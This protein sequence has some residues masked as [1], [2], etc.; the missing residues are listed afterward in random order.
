MVHMKPSDNQRAFEQ[1][2]NTIK[3]ILDLINV[4]VEIEGGEPDT[5]KK[6]FTVTNK[7]GDKI[8]FCFQ[9]TDKGGVVTITNGSLKLEYTESGGLDK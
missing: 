8:G 2:D 4:L 6:S 3:S 5:E 1:Y 9:S 7:A